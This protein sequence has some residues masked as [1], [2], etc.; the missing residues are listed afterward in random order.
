MFKLVWCYVTKMKKNTMIC[1]TGIAVSIMMLFSLVQIG[2][3]IIEYYKGMMVSKSNYD[4]CLGEIDRVTAKE[5][6]NKYKNQYKITLV[7]YLAVNYESNSSSHEVVGIEGDWQTTFD[8]ELL[9][10][11]EPIELNQICVEQSYAKRNN[12]KIGDEI[13]L[14]LVSDTKEEKEEF[15]ITGIVSDAPAYASTGYMFVSLKMAENNDNYYEYMLIDQYDYPEDEIIEIYEY[16]FNTYGSDVCKKIN[17]NDNKLQLAD[18]KGT[19]Y[20][21]RQMIWGIIAFIVVIMTIF[22]YYMMRI[23][24]Q[25]KIRQ[26][27]IMRAIGM[28]NHGMGKVILIELLLYGAWGMVLGSLAGIIF[29]KIFAEK[30]IYVLINERVGAIQTSH[31]IILYVI[32]IVL[33]SMVA[34]FIK[35]MWENRKKMPIDL[36]RNVDKRTMKKR[37]QAKNSMIDIAVNNSFRNKKSSSALMVTML[38]AFLLVILLGNGFGSITFDVNKSM[39]SFSD[40]EVS[41]IYGTV[42][43]WMGIPEEDLEAVSEYADEF[44]CQGA[45]FDIDIYPDYLLLVYSDN[46]MDKLKSINKLSKNTQVVAAGENSNELRNESLAAKTESGET[47]AGVTVEECIGAGLSNL[48]GKSVGGAENYIIVSQD[49]YEKTF[50]EKARWT[51]VYLAGDDLSEDSLRKI[52]SMGNYELYDLAHIMGEESNQL[53]GMLVLIGYMI[54]A[55]VILVVFLITSIV[56]ENFEHRKKEIGMMMA[57]GANMRQMKKI[58][59]G[60]V[61]TLILVSGVVASIIAAPISMYVYLIINEELGMAING[62][63]LGIPVTVILSGLVVYI[64]VSCGLKQRIIDML[65]SED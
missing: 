39:F 57:I 42:D 44:Y 4:L 12:C 53:R 43:M 23:N 11:K 47:V 41:M 60:E 5:L 15:I 38:L 45:I 56:K 10:G 48:V 51:D 22:I 27:G 14:T 61:V 58:L 54:V 17:Q 30:I 33:V 3:T 7:N 13:S 35:I 19:Y 9:E 59:C 2:E 21:M 28:N 8:V 31:K 63:L 55:V 24:F 29:N 6:Q 62:Y 50:G 40:M 52:L 46:L 36:I 32:G 16:V 64:N 26:Y 25:G 34:V 20:G 49:Y 65:R 37:F 1:I 18:N